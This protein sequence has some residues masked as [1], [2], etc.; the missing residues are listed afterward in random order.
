VLL[1]AHA[2]WTNRRGRKPNYWRKTRQFH[3]DARQ[4]GLITLTAV[5][6]LDHTDGQSFREMRRPMLCGY[7]LGDNPR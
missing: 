6:S 2:D 5:E 1:T 4:D 7:I 3:G